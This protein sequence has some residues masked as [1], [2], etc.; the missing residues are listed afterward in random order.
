MRIASLSPG[1]TEIL[2][3]LGVG[4]QIVCLDAES[5]EPEAARAVAHLAASIDSAALVPFRPEIIFTSGQ[6]QEVLAKE[7]R[8]AGLAVVHQCPRSILTLYESIREIG[9]LLQCTA[10]AH[11]LIEEMQQGFNE[12]KRK[13]G[14]FPR[15]PAVF[16]GTWEQGKWSSFP[17]AEDVTR[18]AGG[19][20]V[21]SDTSA[22]TLGELELVALN[23]DLV[24]CCT[25]SGSVT[26]TMFLDEHPSFRSLR[27]ASEGHFFILES[28][29]LD[30]T[31][32][33]LT[34]AAKRLFGWM[35]Q[36]LH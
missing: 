16:V 1:T 35:F 34:V 21:L 31:G 32:P 4:K 11:A 10:R 27:A 25:G 9:V 14:L 23:P 5:D 17:W 26:P 29:L 13:S 22:Q 18:F 15:K 6:E 19:R 33:R 20:S 2:F 3:A 36:V 28:G 30:R 24:V 8:A 7:L 12:V